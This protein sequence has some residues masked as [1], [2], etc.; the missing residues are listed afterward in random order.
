METVLAEIE[1]DVC[2]NTAQQRL[3]LKL[4]SGRRVIVGWIDV[5][6]DAGADVK[7]RSGRR[8]IVGWRAVE[9]DAEADVKLR[10]GRRVIVGWIAVEADAEADV[11]KKG[12]C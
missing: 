11:W 7:L 8:V 2:G 10:S 3:M 5:E 12:D 4:R 1:A 6:A 9:A